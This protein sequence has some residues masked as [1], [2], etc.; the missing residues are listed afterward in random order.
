MEDAYEVVETSKYSLPFK[1]VCAKIG[2]EAKTKLLAGNRVNNRKQA[3][4]VFEENYS[5]RRSLDY[6]Y[7]HKAFN[8]KQ[9]PNETVS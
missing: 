2:G 7:A 5:V 9:R 4:A 3:N 1:F 6:Y 8:S